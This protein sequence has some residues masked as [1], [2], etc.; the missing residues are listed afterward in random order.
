MK[1]TTKVWLIIGTS[2]FL[3]GSILFTIVMSVSNW[4]FRKISTREYQTKEYFIEENY[5]NISIEADEADITFLFSED[6]KTKVVCYEQTVETYAVT[7]TNNTLVINVQ[8]KKKNFLDYI[9]INFQTPKITIILPQK[10]Y[11]EISIKTSTGDVFVKNLCVKTVDISVSTGDIELSSITCDNLI[12][13]G[14]T[15]DVY[16]KNVI[17]T[18]QIYIQRNTGDVEFE[19]CDGAEIFIKTSTG[20]VEGDFLTGKDFIVKSSTGDIEVPKNSAGG[21]C[22]ITTSTGD[23]EIEIRN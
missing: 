13:N 1:K 21:K 15:G 9:Q 23:V 2:L 12:S 8:E 3:A 11:N 16:L 17:A 5:Q 10:E 4:D 6:D 14:S 18:Q 20:D 7:V 22:E 19:S